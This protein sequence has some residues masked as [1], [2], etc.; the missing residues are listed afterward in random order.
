M[1][2]SSTDCLFRD[3]FAIWIMYREKKAVED[4]HLYKGL[5]VK[6][7]GDAGLSED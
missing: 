1:P 4:P 2:Y 3:T 7:W 5:L 6:Q